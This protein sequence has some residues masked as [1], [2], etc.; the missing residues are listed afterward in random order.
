M[1]NLVTLFE[2]KLTRR[3]RMTS[4]ITNDCSIPA[5]FVAGI[6]QSLVITLVIRSL[7]VN[8]L[9]CICNLTVGGI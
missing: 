8:I 5:T 3:L 1:K 4:V 2:G 6:E 7:R 9:I